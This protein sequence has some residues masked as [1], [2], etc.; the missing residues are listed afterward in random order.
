MHNTPIELNQGEAECAEANNHSESAKVDVELQNLARTD[1]GSRCKPHAREV[2]DDIAAT[3]NVWLLRPDRTRDQRPYRYG[4]TVSEV[5]PP[6]LVVQDG[7][8]HER[9]LIEPIVKGSDM[10]R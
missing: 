2:A 1:A 3:S 4:R 7:R 8:T 5:R 6:A 9:I 10:V